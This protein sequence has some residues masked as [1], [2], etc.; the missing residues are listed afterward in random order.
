MTKLTIDKTEINYAYTDGSCV[1][2]TRSGGWGFVLA[3]GDKRLRRS[4][5]EL[6]TTSQRM[7]LLAAIKALEELRGRHPENPIVVRSDSQYLINGVTKWLDNWH[8]NGW[9]NANKE[10]VANP[11]LWI[12]LHILNL[13][14]NVSWE[15]VKGH[16]GDV[17][18][19]EADRLAKDAV[20]R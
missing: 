15:K 4:G 2:Q 20:Q 3:R 12:Q 16:S 17:L 5:S 9:L 11:D 10:P 7:E 18:N 14:L 19:D 8:Q 6:D 1:T 13:T